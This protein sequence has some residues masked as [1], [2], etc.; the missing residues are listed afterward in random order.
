MRRPW[1]AADADYRWRLINVRGSGPAHGLHLSF[2][3]VAI[4]KDCP[5]LCGVRGEFVNGYA[6]DS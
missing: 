1:Q 3:G 5:V 2:G 4:Y 6:S